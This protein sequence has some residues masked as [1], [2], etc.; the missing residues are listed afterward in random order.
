MSTTQDGRPPYC[1]R[2]NHDARKYFV[3]HYNTDKIVST[4]WYKTESQRARAA[5][6]ANLTRDRMNNDWRRGVS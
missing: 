2:A 1:V 3:A 6:L 4:F 5:G